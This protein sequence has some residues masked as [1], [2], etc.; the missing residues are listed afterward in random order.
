MFNIS[1][2]PVGFSLNHS[3]Y[4]NVVSLSEFQ[5]YVTNISLRLFTNW[6]GDNPLYIFALE[7][8]SLSSAEIAHRYPVIPQTN[9]TQWQ[10]IDIPFGEFPIS[11]GYLIGVGMQ[12][13]SDTNQIYTRYSVV[14]LYDVNITNNTRDITFKYNFFQGVAFDYT[15]V[16]N[17]KKQYL[18]KFVFIFSF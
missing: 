15:A 11:T 4:F 8:I 13:R 17:G 16:K 10:T 18:I 1:E 7:Q 2:T 5:G 3:L 6:E 9:N 12:D 14:S